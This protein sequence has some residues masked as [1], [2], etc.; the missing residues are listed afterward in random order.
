MS[1]FEK[2]L[3]KLPSPSK[4]ILIL[5]DNNKS[6]I[7]VK[8]MNSTKETFNTLT[9]FNTT[10][11]LYFTKN[12][13]KKKSTTENIVRL[14]KLNAS[15]IGKN[16]T[17][18]KDLKTNSVNK[19]IIKSQDKISLLSLNGLNY[20]R[21]TE[22]LCSV[23][24]TRNNNN[25]KEFFIYDDNEKNLNNQSNDKDYLNSLVKTSLEENKELGVNMRPNNT[26]KSNKKFYFKLDSIINENE[27]SLSI[28]N[29]NAIQPSNKISRN[30][31]KVS[32]PVRHN[33]DIQVPS[34]DIPNVT[35]LSE[36][37]KRFY[38]SIKIKEDKK[39]QLQAILG[40]INK[41]NF[42]KVQELFNNYA[43]CYWKINDFNECIK[44]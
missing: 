12:L 3:S 31:Q 37:K 33:T 15:K 42:T 41:N 14:N 38:E 11:G 20:K 6:K 19:G 22:I 9:D 2:K 5:K 13:S 34:F 36:E 30:K 24:K 8:E 23:I 32:I 35:E 10:D 4:S 17:P 16:L 26:A 40:Y 28:S 43:K 39:E 18:I 7:D 25:D 29:S 1:F 21:P 27:G 44:K